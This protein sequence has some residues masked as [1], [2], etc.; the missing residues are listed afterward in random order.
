MKGNFWII[1]YME[2][3]L[4]NG[5]I[6]GNSLEFGKIIKWMEKAFLLGL[7]GEDM[8]A[9]IKR[10]KKMDMGCL[11]GMRGKNIKEIGKMENNMERDIYT[12]LKIN[13]GEKAYGKM[14]K[15]L[16]GLNDFLL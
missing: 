15:E 13:L 8:K 16:N 5:L 9:N 4:I 11:N 12:V 7:M 10:I 14:E 1:I 2:K 6:K 3:V